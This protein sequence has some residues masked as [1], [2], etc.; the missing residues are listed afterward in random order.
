M[1]NGR[2]HPR[3]KKDPTHRVLPGVGRSLSP[4]LVAFYHVR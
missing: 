4:L 1:K 3:Y 2:E